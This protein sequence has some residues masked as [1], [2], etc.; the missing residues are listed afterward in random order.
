MKRSTR[1]FTGIVLIILTWTSLPSWAMSLS[2][3]P[4][5]QQS[6]TE[7]LLTYNKPFSIRYRFS[8]YSPRALQKNAKGISLLLYTNPLNDP[9]KIP[10]ERIDSTWE[11]RITVKDTSVKM[12]LFAFQGEDSL[13]LRSELLL[14]NNGGRYWDLLIH[15]ARGWPVRGAHQARAISY[16]GYGGKRR[17]DLDEALIEIRKELRLYSDNYSARSML[18]NLLLRRTD[19]AHN[20]RLDIEDEID[21]ILSKNADDEAVINF[22][23][24]GYRMIGETETAQDLENRLIMK[25]PKGDQA[26]MKAFDAI[27]Q[28]QKPADRAEKLETFLSEYPSNR[29]TEFAL[30]SLASAVIEIDDSTRIEGVGDR[31]LE[32]ASTPGGAAGLSGLAGLL[33]EKGIELDRGS[34]YIQRAIDIIRSASSSDPP[35]NVSSGEWID[36]IQTTEARYRDI[37]GWILFQQDRYEES[38]DELREAAR[39]MLQP[40]VFYH[41]GVVLERSASTADAL[42]HYARAASFG[43]EMGDLSYTAFESLW[44][45]T[46][47]DTSSTRFLEKQEAWVDSIYRERIL[48]KRSV[49]PAPDFELEDITGGWVR[50]DDQE[51]TVIILCFWATWSEASRYLLKELEKV[52]ETFGQKVLFLT[53]AVDTDY[54][55]IEKAVRRQGIIFPVLLNDETD[56]DYELR[57]VPAVFLIDTLGHI[58]FEHQG[59]RPDIENVLIVEIDDLLLR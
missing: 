33:A 36:R 43:G 38:L 34:A 25:N 50:L 27:M 12:V 49:R 14:D 6:G 20:T 41:L 46:L 35:P 13:G 51:D 7:A 23:I 3:I 19:Y 37:Y 31:L 40:I 57:G 9:E 1:L 55:E 45:R 28:I 32:L 56:R 39:S 5:D 18:Y 4:V 59:F 47:G 10:M 22:A 15:D 48:S 58:H 24:G 53:I 16:T 52:A 42:V 54:E 21:E 30:S 26:A 29:F 2:T 17:Q 8:Q 44:S 11:A